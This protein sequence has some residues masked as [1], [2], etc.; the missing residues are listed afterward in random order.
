M[1]EEGTVPYG[2]APSL[3][4]FLA[5]EMKK[6]GGIVLDVHWL[7]C[8]GPWI[9]VV[10]HRAGKNVLLVFLSRIRAPGSDSAK[11]RN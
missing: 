11:Q 8:E 10:L 1:A 6:I 7:C 5:V 3:F 2:V 4:L 9:V